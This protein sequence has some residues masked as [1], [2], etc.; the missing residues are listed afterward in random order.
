MEALVAIM[1]GLLSAGL[2]VLTVASKLV[3]RRRKKV[4]PFKVVQTRA[5]LVSEEGEPL[6]VEEAGK[7][8]V[9]L[10]PVR[11]AKKKTSK[12]KSKKSKR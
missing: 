1:V 11:K 2:L 3:Q 8:E 5:E 7:V 12:K 4:S 9:N 10:K 6:K